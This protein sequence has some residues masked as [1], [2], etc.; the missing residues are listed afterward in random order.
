MSHIVKD[1]DDLRLVKDIFYEFLNSEVDISLL[2][3]AVI[4]LLPKDMNGNLFSKY[5]IKKIDG[6]YSR[7][8]LGDN[9]LK[10]SMDEMK[11]WSEFNSLKLANR[12]S[13]NDLDLFRKYIFFSII[14]HEIEHS[15]QYLMAND[16]VDSPSSLVSSLYKLIID[17]LVNNSDVNILKEI[18]NI[19]SYRLY[20]K[21]SGRYV[22]ERNANVEAFDLMQK[23]AIENEHMEIADTFNRMRNSIAI[24]GYLDNNKGSFYET[25]KDMKLIREYKKFDHDYELS[26]I[27]RFRYGLPVSND[28]M[29]KIK[30][31]KK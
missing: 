26:D 23:L 7:F 6:G 24:W 13:V 18:R 1:K 30:I 27:E 16:L 20:N 12:F 3:E 11:R 19:I 28:F 10:L 21:N 29:G 14:I 2:E 9:Y 25:C 17:T 31:I 15:Y 8:C 22:I 4:N 5:E